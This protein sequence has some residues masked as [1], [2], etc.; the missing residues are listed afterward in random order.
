MLLEA[1]C[2]VLSYLD[3]FMGISAPHTTA[4]HHAFSGLLLEA[5][6]LQELPHKACPP[7]TQVTCLGVLFDMINFTMSITPDRL[8]EL[9]EDLLPRWLVKKS[10]TRTELQSLIGKLAFVCKCVRPGRLFLTCILD[11]LRSLRRNHHRTRINA[12]FQKD[13]R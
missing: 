9:Q 12:E 10:M 5:L 11:T 2:N 7:S 4:N 13:I 3:D 6:G 8:R 1:S